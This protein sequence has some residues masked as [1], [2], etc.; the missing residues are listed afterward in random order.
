MTYQQSMYTFQA[1][2]MS[3]PP[4]KQPDVQA[5]YDQ[6]KYPDS[7]EKLMCHQEVMDLFGVKR[8][9]IISWRKNR[10]FPEPITSCPL[11]WLRTAVFEWM[12]SAGGC[13]E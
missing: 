3:T 9:A 13:K 7:N 8:G 10:G 11:R 5:S 1:P 4:A 12:E 6:D 2:C